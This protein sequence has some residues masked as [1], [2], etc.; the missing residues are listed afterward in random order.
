MAIPENRMS[1]TPVLDDYIP[2]SGDTNQ[3]LEWHQGGPLGIGDT[4]GG[5]NNQDWIMT[6]SDP[7]FT[8]SPQTTGIPTVVH[9]VANV[10]QLSF[11]FD[12]NANF[13]I[14]YTALGIA[15]LYWFDTLAAM[16]VTTASA[17]GAISPA[18][19]LDDKRDTQTQANDMIL[20]YTKQEIDLSYTLFMRMQRERFENEYQM[21]TNVRPHIVN[22]GMNTGL[23]LQVSMQTEFA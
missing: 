11:C 19:T 9:S 3:L 16:Y 22:L 13:T 21:A 12:Q 15:Y 5:Q 18:V 7:D 4:S 14:T 23:R 20:M 10:T 8:L 17:L 6:Y 2:P 1:T